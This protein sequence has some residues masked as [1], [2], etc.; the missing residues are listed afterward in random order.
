MK[1]SKCNAELQPT[2]EL[3]WEC[4]SCHQMCRANLPMLEQIQAQRDHGY[5]A[6]MVN[7]PF[8]GIVLD[9]GNETIHWNCASCGEQTTGTI[10][11]YLKPELLEEVAAPIAEESSDQSEFAWIDA[12]GE[13]MEAPPAEKPSPSKGFFA[14]EEAKNEFLAETTSQAL[15]EEIPDSIF[16][17]AFPIHKKSEEKPA[18]VPAEN[19]TGIPENGAADAISGS[20][21]VEPPTSTP[22]APSASQSAEAPTSSVTDTISGSP[23]V[24]PPTSTP[25]APPASQPVEAPTSSVTDTISGSPFVEPPTS[26]PTA[27]PASQ[28]AETPASTAS[29]PSVNQPAGASVTTADTSAQPP[30]TS[31]YSYTEPPVKQRWPK[32]LTGI[33]GVMIAAAVIVGVFFTVSYLIAPTR[34]F[35]NA[36]KVA[37]YTKAMEIYDNKIKGDVDDERIAQ[38]A[39]EHYLHEAFK[40]LKDGTGDEAAYEKILDFAQNEMRIKTTDY[41]LAAET[42]A[43]PA[44]SE[45][46]APVG[47]A[48]ATASPETVAEMTATPEATAESTPE[49]TEEP[50]AVTTEPVAEPTEA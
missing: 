18:E 27:P 12:D 40:A 42:T 50:A 38:I 37:D 6:A 22:T 46:P 11:N 13:E 9:D 23:F 2:D 8:C 16:E 44:P 45:S 26:T 43:T 35:R 29:E 20:P 47:E 36:V 7:C 28:P 21:F 41:E 17:D 10:K 32:I 15:G 33:L 25:T 19:A 34:Q 5:T 30:Q 4:N 24:E 31:G 48:E 49:V 3:R 39:V 14:D 1:C